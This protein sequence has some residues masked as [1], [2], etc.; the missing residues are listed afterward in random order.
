MKYFYITHLKYNSCRSYLVENTK[1]SLN[2][3]YNEHTDLSFT[4]EL[5]EQIIS[6]CSSGCTWRDF[7]N[8]ISIAVTLP[9]VE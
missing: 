3:W 1:L 7:E 2:E 8:H 6:Y 9:C 4:D 5:Y